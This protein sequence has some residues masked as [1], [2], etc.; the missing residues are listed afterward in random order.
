MSM[1]IDCDDILKDNLLNNFLS[2]KL[3]SVQDANQQLR[4]TIADAKCSIVEAEAVKSDKD[5]LIVRSVCKRYHNGKWCFIV[6]VATL[7]STIMY[8]DFDVSLKWSPIIAPQY[9]LTIYSNDVKKFVTPAKIATE[10]RVIVAFESITFARQ[11]KYTAEVVLFYAA[12]DN[13]CSLQLGAF[14]ISAAEMNSGAHEIKNIHL[15]NGR[16]EDMLAAVA[17]SVE[18]ELAMTL[19]MGVLRD[20]LV[21]DCMFREVVLDTN[22]WFL[23]NANAEHLNGC[24]LVYHFDEQDEINL[25]KLY[26]RD[27]VH[28]HSVLHH[29]H[30][31]MKGVTIMSL[32]CKSQ[33]VKPNRDCEDEIFSSQAYLQSQAPKR[34]DASVEKFAESLHRQID[35]VIDF[36]RNVVGNKEISPECDVTEQY[37]AM[38]NSLTQ[39][40]STTDLLY[41]HLSK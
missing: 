1:D 29:L 32:K 7:D 24:L 22:K 37:H 27:K 30:S 39:H 12:D 38:R 14:C 33:L 5:R 25:V 3:K 20:Y 23:L 35:S 40:E 15:I 2:C 8:K 17:C 34:V 19:P 26:V 9:T 18:I 31:S 36:H 13:I 11:K 16:R 41:Q 28:L 10:I 4:T 21:I 6:D